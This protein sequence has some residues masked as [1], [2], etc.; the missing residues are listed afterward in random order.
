MIYSVEGWELRARQIGKHTV[1]QQCAT[2]PST[3]TGECLP[4]YRRTTAI[5]T[6]YSMANA[7][8]FHY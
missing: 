2:Q 1:M 7:T 3:A 6:R 4:L 8:A 5:Q